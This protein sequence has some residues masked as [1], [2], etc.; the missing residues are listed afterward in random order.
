MTTDHTT[1]QPALKPCPH[2][3]AT[4]IDPEMWASASTSGPGCM[5]CGATA[6]TAEKWNHRPLEAQARADAL[7]EAAEVC[8]N[9]EEW[10]IWGKDV[11]R[12]VATVGATDCQAAILALIGGNHG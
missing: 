11:N 8:A 6:E 4:D 12:R 9:Y 7:R 3:S 10:A 5:N 1:A 2:C